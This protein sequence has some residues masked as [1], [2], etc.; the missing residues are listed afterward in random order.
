MISK[1]KAIKIIDLLKKEYSHS[2]TLLKYK[3][4]FQLLIATILSAQCSDK[5]VNEITPHIFK[6][7][8]D[9]Y[10]FLRAKT[11]DLEQDIYSSGF[12]KN[13][14]KNIISLSRIL[15]EDF[16][17]L[18]PDNM[19]D[20]IQL[21]GVA[22]K[23]ANIVLSSIF[24]KAEGIAVDTHVK[25]LSR[26]LDFSNSQNTDRIEIDLMKLFPKR[27][28]LDLNYIL[29]NQGRE[30]CKSRKPL[31]SGCVVKQLCGSEDKII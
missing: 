3:T 1:S 16:N 6:K 29:V 15:V 21:P 19:E 25:R 2:K 17:G 10:G 9:V 24:K 5:K 8:K 13:K 23:T 12:Y 30:V 27:Y 26:R 22:R 28:W 20:L 4:P 14:A 18:V 11:K 31:C 7:Y